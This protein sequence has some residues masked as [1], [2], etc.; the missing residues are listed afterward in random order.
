ME[1][2]KFGPTTRSIPVIGQGTW[3]IEDD[4]P[5][6]TIATLRAGLDLGMTHIDTAEL[7]GSGVVEELVGRAIAGRRDEVFLV[8]KV[9][10]DNASMR[11]T[12]VACENSLARLKTDR[13]D[14]YLLHWPGPHPL[15]ETI[16]GFE[17][18][19]RQG[20]ILSWGLSNFDVDDLEEAV[21]IAGEG[22]IA[23]NQVF[24]H[25]RERAIEHAV[26]PWCENH[27][28]AVV[29]Y[30]PFGQ[31]KTAFPSAKSEGGRVLQQIAD[32]H[33]ATP[34]Q[35]AL[36]F[37]TRRKSLFAIPK[38]ADPAHMKDNAAASGFALG[39]AEIA[40]IEAAFPR[41]ARRALPMI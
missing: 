16:A 3:L 37:L 24:Y 2:R 26:V 18:L 30:S 34:R 35:V 20:K 36:A 8:S 31:Y 40:A 28:I 39:R 7:Y 1:Q 17:Q 25:L 21:A 9:L 27:G 10:P 23:C 22:A 32:A 4:P 14:C 11:G 33:G 12:I 29:A 5:E 19:R 41:G 6:R 38:A 15:R 13:L